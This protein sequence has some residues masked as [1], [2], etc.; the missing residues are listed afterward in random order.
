MRISCFPKPLDQSFI[1]FLLY[2][3]LGTNVS[4]LM[5][6]KKPIFETLIKT[7]RAVGEFEVTGKRYLDNQ[8]DRLAPGY[9]L[10]QKGKQLMYKPN[11]RII[12]SEIN[13]IIDCPIYPLS[14]FSHQSFR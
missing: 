9:I 7:Y 13:V 2:V 11:I 10:R 4:C 6:N 14:V 5:P 12:K 3:F 1:I 8:F